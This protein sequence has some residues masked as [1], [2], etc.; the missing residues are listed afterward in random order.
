MLR[1]VVN[2]FS[3]LLDSQGTQVLQKLMHLFCLAITLL[4]K[5]AHFYFNLN[6]L[7]FILRHF[8]FLFSSHNSS[9]LLFSLFIISSVLLYHKQSSLSFSFLCFSIICHRKWSRSSSFL[10][11]ISHAQLVIEHIKAHRS[12]SHVM[13]RSQMLKSKDI[14]ESVVIDTL[15][16]LELPQANMH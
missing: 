3:A 6:I 5:N 14:M 12:F 11:N 10:L 2:D 13:H 9:Q 16:P 1:K 15:F 8:Y 4:K 7:I